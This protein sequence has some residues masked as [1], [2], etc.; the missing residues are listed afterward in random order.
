[1]ASI[2][3]DISILNGR[4]L[5]IATNFPIDCS[6]FSTTVKNTVNYNQLNSGLDFYVN[7][8][9][10]SHYNYTYDIIDGHFQYGKLVNGSMD[11]ILGMVN[12]SV[13][14]DFIKLSLI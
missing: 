1:M 8:F 12:R 9:L 7:Q 11:G 10:A 2:Y 14:G 3:S 5:K 4:H 6:S 13:R